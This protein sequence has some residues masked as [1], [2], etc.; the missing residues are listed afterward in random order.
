LRRGSQIEPIAVFDTRIQK[1]RRLPGSAAAKAAKLA[2]RLGYAPA[3]RQSFFVSDTS[4]PLLPGELER[5]RAWGAQLAVEM[6]DRA[7]GQATV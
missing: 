4:G 3:G 7:R 2:S 6:S 5:A 1:A